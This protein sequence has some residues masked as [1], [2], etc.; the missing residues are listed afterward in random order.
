MSFLFSSLEERLELNGENLPGGQRE[1]E[2]E[3]AIPGTDG[4]LC[5]DEVAQVLPAAEA[6][7]EPMGTVA[8]VPFQLEVHVNLRSPAS[9]YSG[10]PGCLEPSGRHGLRSPAAVSRT[11]W[12]LCCSPVLLGLVC[13]LGCVLPM[14]PAQ[15]FANLSPP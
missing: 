15:E 6:L 3:P 9:L 1:G 13:L 2:G 8:E 5:W 4:D 11:C 7:I 14:G 12:T 10:M